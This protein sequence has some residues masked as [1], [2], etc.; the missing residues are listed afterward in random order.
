ML[1]NPPSASSAPLSPA[2]PNKVSGSNALLR[3]HIQFLE[4]EP[5]HGVSISLSDIGDRYHCVAEQDLWSELPG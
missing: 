5:L 3:K 1:K 4:R 2:V